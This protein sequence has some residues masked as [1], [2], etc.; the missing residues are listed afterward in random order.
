MCTDNTHAVNIN[1][2]ILST[3]KYPNYRNICRIRY[4]ISHHTLHVPISVV[5]ERQLLH[6]QISICSQANYN[7][8]NI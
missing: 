6:L 1:I 7:I 4:W 3:K 2:N 8:L 5:E